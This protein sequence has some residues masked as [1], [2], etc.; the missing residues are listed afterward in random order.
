MSL[1]LSISKLHFPNN[2]DI[3][4]PITVGLYI[5][6]YYNGTYAL[7]QDNVSVGVDGTIMESPLPT[8]SIDPTQK[9]VIKAVNESCDF[10]Y[11]QEVIINP[12][13]PPGYQIS[14]D[15]TYCF[16][17]IVTAAT[18]PS[19]PENSVAVNHM[20][21]TAWGSLIYD[22]GFNINGTGTFTQI[23]YVNGFWVNGTGYPT[24]SG[25]D[26]VQGPLNRTGLWSTTTTGSSQTIGFSVC[27]TVPLD[28]VYYIGTGSDNYTS[29]NVDSINIITMDPVAMG[30]YL[31]ANGY[32]GVG[33]ESTF[34][35]WHIYPVFLNAGTHILEVIGNNISSVAS[36]GVE[37]YNASSSDLQAATS[38]IGLGAKLIFSSK[39]F[40]GSPIQLG[41]DGIGYS[42]PSGYALDLCGSPIVCTRF[43]KTPIL[44]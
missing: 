5:K 30:A 36:I 15:E 26:T 12:Y 29:I 14:S 19:S 38:Y 6:A 8:V 20:D 24:G 39:D 34:R 28:G 32:P 23:P 25:T 42:C 18:P 27:V 1:N 40:I 7:I 35:F 10:V 3:V 31:S 21:Y 4:N 9:Y 17:E 13:C 16:F 2:G 11:E 22:S 37:I 44:Y 33:V 41:S 43:V